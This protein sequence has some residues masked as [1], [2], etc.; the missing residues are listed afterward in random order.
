M[1]AGELAFRDSRAA[2]LTTHSPA[3][4]PRGP[5]SPAAL[6][7]PRPHGPAART[8]PR[9]TQALWC[10]GTLR[11]LGGV[12]P[13]RSTSV[14]VAVLVSSFPIAAAAPTMA[15]PSTDENA[16]ARSHGAQEDLAA[17]LRKLLE[18]QRVK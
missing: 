18:E 3:S 11:I 10:T 7:P 17:K 2:I 9:A 14:W 12:N 1:R 15:Q 8:V 4:C 6:A 13:M 16:Q 5:N